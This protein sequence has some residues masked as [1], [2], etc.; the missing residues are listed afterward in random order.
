[1]SLG[2]WL[3]PS[4]LRQLFCAASTSLIAHIAI[5][6]SRTFRRHSHRK[7]TYI[8]DEPAR[9]VAKGRELAETTPGIVIAPPR[10]LGPLHYPPGIGIGRN[11]DSRP[12]G[13]LVNPVFRHS[14]TYPQRWSSRIFGRVWSPTD[15]PN[16]RTDDD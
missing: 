6:R 9:A 5:S 1:M 11:A 16:R 4:S 7:A 14:A 13:N 12:H 2:N 10:R 15:Q 8:S 3:W